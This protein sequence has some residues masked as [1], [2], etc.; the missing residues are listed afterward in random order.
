MAAS[1]DDVKA[2]TSFPTGYYTRR[3][4]GTESSPYTYTATTD[5]TPV[6]GTTYYKKYA[7][8]GADIRGN[9]YGGGNQAEVTGDTHVQIG[10]KA[11]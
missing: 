9:V 4:E 6:E 7:I 3:G 10:K 2:D 1:D 11:E 8:K 5:T